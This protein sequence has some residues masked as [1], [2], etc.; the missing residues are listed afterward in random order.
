MSFWQ[1][2]MSVNKAIV[3]TEVIGGDPLMK[4]ILSLP[5]MIMAD[6]NR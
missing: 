3:K 4:N 6:L 2:H 1:R 5:C